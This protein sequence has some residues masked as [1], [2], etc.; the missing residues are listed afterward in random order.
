ML[1]WEVL[2]YRPASPDVVIARWKTGPSGLRWL[3]RLAKDNKA[4]DLGGNGYP[5]KYTVVAGVLLPILR[6]GLPASDSAL[7]IG[8]DYVL[9]AGWS[10]DLDW[11]QPEALACDRNDQLVVEAWDQS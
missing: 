5:D 8:T 11:N 6:A 2:V 4:V 1:G 10:S 7:V 9:P 3:D